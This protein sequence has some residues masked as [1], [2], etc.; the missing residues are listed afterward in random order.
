MLHRKLA[1]FVISLKSTC[2]I[3][4][5]GIEVGYAPFYYLK[6]PLSDD[7]IHTWLLGQLIPREG[8]YVLNRHYA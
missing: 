6:C 4:G 5:M 3:S 8:A 7:V 2:G 1:A